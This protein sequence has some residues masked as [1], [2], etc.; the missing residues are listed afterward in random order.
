MYGNNKENE[1]H[2]K[3][4]LSGNTEFYFP[5]NEIEIS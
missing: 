2:L 1:G 4:G 3:K 5:Q